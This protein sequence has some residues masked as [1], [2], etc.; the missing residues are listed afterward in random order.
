MGIEPTSET[1]DDIG[2]PGFPSLHIGKKK[3]IAHAATSNRKSMQ[4]LLR[5][6]LAPGTFFLPHCDS[7]ILSSQT[8]VA[9]DPLAA[10]DNGSLPAAHTLRAFL[11]R[12]S[13]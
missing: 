10:Y 4:R 1:S 9:P 6:I 11:E 2:Y 12:D 7:R 8:T 3:M 13:E 5:S